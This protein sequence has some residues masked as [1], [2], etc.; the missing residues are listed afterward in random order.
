MTRDRV[1]PNP[2]QAAATSCTD[3]RPWFPAYLSGQIALTERVLVE[4]HLKQCGRCRP[5]D[6]RRHEMDGQRPAT[7]W[8]AALDSLVARGWSLVTAG[9]TEAASRIIAGLMQA[10]SLGTGH[11]AR[12]LARVQSVRAI[13]LELP[14]LAMPRWP[15][16]PRPQAGSPAPSRPKPGA[17]P[18]TRTPATPVE[19]RGFA[20][21]RAAEASGPGSPAPPSVPAPRAAGPHVVGRLSAKDRGA[22]ERAFIALLSDV[23]G[24]ELDRT[25]HARFTSVDVIVPHAGYREFTHGLGRIGS[26]RLEATTFSLPDA[27]RMTIRMSE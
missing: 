27:V 4:A 20:R 6:V 26:W 8:R 23:Q 12:L 1:A 17:P 10:V 5:E 24:T 11:G 2:P 9:A 19:P 7:Q 22:A 13:A 3:V 16:G 15:G 21:P 25:R 14:G 18:V